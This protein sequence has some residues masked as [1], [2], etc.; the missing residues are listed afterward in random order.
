MTKELKELYGL[1]YIKSEDIFMSSV[2]STSVTHCFLE[3][4]E[5]G[6]RTVQTV[7]VRI[8][9]KG[10]ERKSLEFTYGEMKNTDEVAKQVKAS[11][12]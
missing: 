11:I 10:T 5:G 9:H 4:K 12:S 3:R 1:K 8:V 6:N 7:K 2:L